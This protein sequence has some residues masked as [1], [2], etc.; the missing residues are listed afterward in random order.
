[1]YDDEASNSIS[2]FSNRSSKEGI[3][4]TRRSQDN[5]VNHSETAR[6]NKMVYAPLLLQAYHIIIQCVMFIVVMLNL[7]KSNRLYALIFIG[8]IIVICLTCFKELYRLSRALQIAFYPMTATTSK[9]INGEWMKELMD[10]P[11]III[12]ACTHTLSWIQ[13]KEAWKN[14][15]IKISNYSL[16]IDLLF[17]Q[18]PFITITI[19]TMTQMKQLSIIILSICSLF[20]SL[21]TICYKLHRAQNCRAQ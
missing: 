13:Y 16:C 14:C 1:M 17:E 4:P 11:W 2:P 18:T 12:I 6:T 5:I 15:K 7:T 8:W 3:K 20:A 10:S 21:L 9:D 19:I